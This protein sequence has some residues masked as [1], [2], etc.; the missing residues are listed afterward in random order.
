LGLLVLFPFLVLIGIAI[1]L[2][3]KG[4]ILFKQKRMLCEGG[5]KILVYKFRTMIEGAEEL[6]KDISRHKKAKGAIYKNKDDNRVTRVG[7]FLRRFSID[8]L[9]QL[10][11]V[12][13]G[14][15]SLVGPRPFSELVFKSLEDTSYYSYLCKRREEAFPGITGL[16]QVNGRADITFDK[17]LFFDFYYIEHQSLSLD[18]EILFKT[19]SIVITCKGAY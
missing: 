14:N 6:T 17:M 5:K 16:W 3:S 15:M 12:L 1:K 13:Q 11:N 2:E 10:I 18:L 19:I 7:E 8:E 9:P 4:P